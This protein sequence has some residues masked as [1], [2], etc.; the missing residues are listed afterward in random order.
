MANTIKVNKSS[1]TLSI[2]RT[3]N[4]NYPYF[5]IYLVRASKIENNE[6]ITINIFATREGAEEYADNARKE[7]SELYSVVWVRD[8]LV[9][10]E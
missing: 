5:K 10:C 4:F 6:D 9:W 7:F 3:E 2:E 1:V 8:E